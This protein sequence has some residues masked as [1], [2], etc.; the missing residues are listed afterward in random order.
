MP[1]YV[2][3]ATGG[4]ASCC[5]NRVRIVAELMSV[6]TTPGTCSPGV[7]GCACHAQCFAWSRSIGSS[8]PY[9]EARITASAPSTE[10][11]P[12][13]MPHWYFEASV[14]TSPCVKRGL[15]FVS[16]RTQR[17]PATVREERDDRDRAGCSH[18]TSRG[19]PGSSWREKTHGCRSSSSNQ[20]QSNWQ[21]SVL[22][23]R[24]RG[25][26]VHRAVLRG[27]RNTASASQ[28]SYRRQRS[29]SGTQPKPLP[30]CE[31]CESTSR[32][33]IYASTN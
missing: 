5:S 15:S 9:G 22:P 18:S 26:L 32:H 23:L 8:P 24:R 6:P 21:Q 11:S 13:R 20:G 16:S 1:R 7:L 4:S 17:V 25:V 29:E 28:S 12:R 14:A 3:R 33:A 10:A 2:G 30:P 19:P 27:S 31:S